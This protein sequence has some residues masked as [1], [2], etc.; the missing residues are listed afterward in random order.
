[1]AYTFLGNATFADGKNIIVNAATGTMIATAVTQ[2]IGFWGQTP[3]V[4]PAGAGQAIVVA[5]VDNSGGASGG[6][7]IAV[8]TDNASAAN[9]IA[10]LAAKVNALNVLITALRLGLVNSGLVKGAA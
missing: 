2:K 9:A 6:D 7:T 8:V 1:V 4:Q 3:I 5:L 10:T